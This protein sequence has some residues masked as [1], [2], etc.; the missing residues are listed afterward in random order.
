MNVMNYIFPAMTTIRISLSACE[1]D[2]DILK[3]YEDVN[4][5]MVKLSHVVCHCAASHKTKLIVSTF[6]NML[7]R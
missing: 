7:L 1:R 5:S 6:L 2:N 3:K 4:W